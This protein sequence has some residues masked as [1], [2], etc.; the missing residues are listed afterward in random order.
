MIKYS[1]P[2]MIPMNIPTLEENIF[3]RLWIWVTYIR[4]W[5][6][7]NSWYHT[8]PDGKYIKINT[9]FIF[10]GVSTPKIFWAFLSPTGLLFLPA[11]VHDQIYKN[12]GILM[13]ENK[14]DLIGH[15]PG[16][17]K[18][19]TQKEADE[20]FLS[21]ALQVNGFCIIETIA[22]YLLRLVGWM[23]WNKHRRNEK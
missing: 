13:S 17:F 22:F 18:E 6:L 16:L 2:H 9:G 7:I 8:L 23:A 15:C 10:D 19:F 14:G 12:K 20:L 11:I 5:K 21:I 3:T 1:M 4:K